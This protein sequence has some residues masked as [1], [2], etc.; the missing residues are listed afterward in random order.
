MTKQLITSALPYV[1]GLP[2]LGHLIGCLLPSDVYAR[3]LRQK[4]QEVLYV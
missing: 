2:H 1:N 3:Y 4:G